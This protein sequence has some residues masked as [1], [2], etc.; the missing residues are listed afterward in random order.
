MKNIHR[1]I[2]LVLVGALLSGCELLK[3]R[4]VTRTTY[5][6]P[7]VPSKLLEPCEAPQPPDR[8]YY[9]KQDPLKRESMLTDYS[10]SLLHT[11][12]TCNEKL[13]GVKTFIEDTKRVVDEKN[14]P[15]KP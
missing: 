7:N 3:P 11:V 1:V 5:V 10:I 12:S 15:E 6:V 2:L 8:E 14:K 4:V 9:V 13:Q